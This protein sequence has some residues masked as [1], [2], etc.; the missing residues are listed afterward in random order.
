[1]RNRVTGVTA[2]L[3]LASAALAVAQAPA[4]QASSRPSSISG[5][6][7]VGIRATTTNGDEAR[8]ERYR[9]T[10]S[11]AYSNVVFGKETA[12]YRVD[13]EAQNVGYR[14]QRYA[15]EY[16]NRKMKLA[17]LWDS[18]PLNYAYNASTPWVESSSGNVWTLDTAARTAVQNRQA[19]IVGIPSTAAA[20]LTPSIY[21]GLATTFT[22]Q[23]R[24]DT[25]GGTL[26]YEATKDLGITLGFTST[27]KSGHQ[28]FGMSFAFNNANE[29]PMQLDNR[30]N[31]FSLAVEWTRPKGMARAA[32][33]YSAFS[34]QFNAVEWDNP[35]RATDYSNGLAASTLLGPYDPSGYSNGN[36]PAKGR[37]SSFPDNSM[38][39]V[40]L[41]GMYKLPHRTTMN[42]TLQIASMSQND[43]LIPWTTNGVINTSEVW[44]VFPG[45]RSL[46]RATA[47]TKVRAIDALLNFASRPTKKVGFTAKYRHNSHTNNSD[48]FDATEYVRFDA[49]PEET[50]SETEFHDITRD[51]FDGAMSYALWPRTTLRVGYGYSRVEHTHR[52]YES[53]S[54]NSVRATLDTIGN[55][56]YTVRIGY[57]HAKRTGQGFDEA[58]LTD[59]GSQSALRFYDDAE[60]NRDRASGL[61]VFTPV[62]ALNITGTVA[63]GKDDYGGGIEFGLLNNKNT[64][65]NVGVEFSPVAT[66]S[67][68]ANYGRDTFTAVQQSRNSNPDPDPQWTDA[69]RNWTMT[70]D[71]SVN[72]VDI[73][74]D[75]LKAVR[76]TDIRFAYT[77]SDSDNA[78]LHGG[79]RIPALAA[80]GQFLALPNVTNIW[81]RLTADV[82]YAAT[83]KIGIAVG[84]W[85]EKMDIADYGTINLPNSAQPRIDYLGGLTT[86]YGNRPYKGSTGIV[87]IVYSF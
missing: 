11:G 64:S 40:S 52:T 30:T 48:V 82:R 59:S 18:I 72:N 3:L 47:E 55:R 73:Y 50:G 56:F 8:F 31:D 65:Y 10:R 41:M 32:I 45:L 35:I 83:D 16:A 39:V 9:D 54:D 19:G 85:Y 24:R 51:V 38:A 68:G 13:V 87:R 22:M 78:F 75:V 12:S 7:D 15:L 6:A 67:V 2:A 21:R 34:N 66:V 61:V 36:G 62:D 37:M 28:P 14:D 5:T 33:E 43:D 26:T 71:E 4:D 74:L 42:G 25:T 53:L 46:E 20:L 63:Y 69:T 60:R 81:Q 17:L 57:E 27:H 77:Y 84:Y 86:G 80:I 70:N 23:Q 76:K 29:L 44:A 1:M 49:V 79:P 58:S